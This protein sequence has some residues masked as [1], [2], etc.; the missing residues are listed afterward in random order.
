MQPQ[1]LK[2]DQFSSY[3]PEARRLVT[4]HLDALRQLPLSFVP[5]LLR[6]A[7]EYDYKF[8]AE[9]RAIDREL[10][11]LSELSPMQRR[12]WFQNFNEFSLPPQLEDFDW[13]NM[14]AQFTEQLSAYLWSTHQLD[15]YHDAASA[16]G[17]RIQPSVAP[18]PLPTQRLG[19]AVI[20]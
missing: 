17:A 10:K 3:P 19:I 2:S 8:P 4:D 20:G 14:P 12:E 7:I 11:T 16:Y 1:D 18:E 9:R 6:E 5:G 13:V 15:A